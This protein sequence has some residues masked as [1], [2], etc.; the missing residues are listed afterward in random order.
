MGIT[1][2]VFVELIILACMTMGDSLLP[3]SLVGIRLWNNVDMKR[4]IQ[5]KFWSILSLKM[6]DKKISPLWWGHAI[7]KQEIE[8]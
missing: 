2:I 3:C 7:P 8:N 5:A 1:P 4:Q 6:I